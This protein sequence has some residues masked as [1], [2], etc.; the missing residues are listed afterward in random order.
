MSPC[1][2]SIP[3]RP[4]TGRR[5][6]FPLSFTRCRIKSTLRCLYPQGRHRAYHVSCTY[7][8]GLGPTYSPGV[9]HLRQTRLQRLILTTYL[10]VQAYQHLSLVNFHDV[11]RWFT[12]VDHTAPSWFPTTLVLAITAAARAFAAIRLA[13]GATLSQELRTSPLPVTHVLV[14]YRWQNSG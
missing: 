3:I 6:L 2:S 13:D 9:Y 10:L 1:R 12:Y 4:N 8:C 14:G 7:L 11:Y 5:S